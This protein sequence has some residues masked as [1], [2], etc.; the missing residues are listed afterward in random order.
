VMVNSNPETVSTDYDVSD[1]LFFEPVTFEDVMHIVE[2]VK[3][4]GVIVQLGGQTP[5]NLAEKLSKAGVPIFGTSAESIA[6]AEDRDLFKNL[7]N[8][9]G[10]RQPKNGIYSG[11]GDPI[12]LAESI[13]YPVVV[14]PSYVLGGRAMEIVYNSEDLREYFKNV[15]DPSSGQAI[16]IDQYLE[17][18]I[19]VDVDCVSD[20]QEV[21]ICGI[22]EHIEEAGIHSGDSACVLPAQTIP[23]NLMKQ[24]EDETKAMALALKVKGLMNVQFAIKNGEL[25]FIEVNPRGSRTVPFVCK[26]SGIPWV[27]VAVKV[28]AGKKL[29][30]LSIPRKARAYVAVKEAVLPF[31]KFPNE[32]TIL[33][34]EMKSTGEVM[35]IGKNLGEAYYKAQL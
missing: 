11:T 3:P 13:G 9:L 30:E 25:Y 1:S 7:L 6:I 16:L 15:L 21:A 5:L 17:R 32:D 34:P 26:A 35:G 24:I 10:F 19:E 18:A 14:R 23:P 29:G 12:A 33:G 28:M 4:K 31:D 22:M 2:T 8:K 27:N 20:G